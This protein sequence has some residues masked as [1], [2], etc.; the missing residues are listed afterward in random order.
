[1]AFLV[2][3]SAVALGSSRF[4][5]KQGDSSGVDGADFLVPILAALLISTLAFDD[6]QQKLAAVIVLTL[7]FSLG[8]RALRARR[9]RE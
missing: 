3:L 9:A 1:M 7:L 4:L 2:A 6:D 5:G 8:W